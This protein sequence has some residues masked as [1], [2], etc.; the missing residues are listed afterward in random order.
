[1]KNEKEQTH[2]R[3]S[4]YA[5]FLECKG[6][7][8]FSSSS[9][10]HLDETIGLELGT[11]VPFCELA[12]LIS[13]CQCVLVTK[14]APSTHAGIKSFSVQCILTV[15]SCQVLNSIEFLESHGISS[16]L[17]IVDL[18]QAIPTRRIRQCQGQQVQ[19]NLTHQCLGFPWLPESWQL[20][21]MLIDIWL[22]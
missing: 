1:M 19:N 11:C 16:L 10:T 7:S 2:R 4:N 5:C 12:R 8:N 13:R 17:P 18:R 21:G 15:R 14:R 3:I 9:G 20:Q 22:I 6:E